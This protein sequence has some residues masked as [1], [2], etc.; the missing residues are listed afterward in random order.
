MMDVNRFIEWAHACLL[1]SEEAQE[2]LLSR[3]VSPDQWERHNIGFTNGVFHPDPKDDIK[4]NSNCGDKDYKGEWCDTC[5]YI[6]WSTKWKKENEDDSKKVP[7]IGG[8][9]INS[10]VLPLTT[11]SGLNIGFQVRSIHEKSYATY[12]LS[13]RPEGYFFG[14]SS[15]IHSIWSKKSVILTEGPF[16]HLLIDRLVSNNVLA[17]TTSSP[18]KTQVNFIRRFADVIYCCLDNDKAGR[19]GF[20]AISEYLKEKHIIKLNFPKLKD[21]DKDVGD[22]WKRVGDNKF[23][24]HFKCQLQY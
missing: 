18:G 19:E 6:R 1:D 10:I 4:H 16:D 3:G 8:N 21:N 13:R 9:I 12:C 2:Y 22:F 7:V 20:E 5:R 15:S 24:E 23:R 17:I 14:V 11:Y